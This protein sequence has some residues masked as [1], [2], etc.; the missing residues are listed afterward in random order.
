MSSWH[1]LTKRLRAQAVPNPAQESLALMEYV[2]G[3]PAATILADE[4]PLRKRQRRRLRRLADRRQKQPLAYLLGQQ[5]FYGL[6]FII[7][8]PVLI[9]RPESEDMVE[10]AL[11]LPQ[12]FNQVYDLGSGSGCLGI[13]YAHAGGC[14][15]ITFIDRDQRAL[16]LTALNSQIHGL[17]QARYQ[18]RS[19][20]TMTRADFRAGSLILANLP[21]LD[22]NQ[23]QTFEDHCPTLKREAAGALYA[24]E[25]GLY[26]Y[27]LLFQ[28]CPTQTTLLCESLPTQQ[29]R[30][31]QLA[32]TTGWQLRHQHNFISMFTN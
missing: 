30:L 17:H 26:Y 11:S 6:N 31:A 24:P 9:P 21:Y 20:E 7:K 15:P 12:T 10:L 19:L 32:Q 23:R 14:Q 29:D 5:Q 22:I 2:T 28:R 4:I 8:P 13:A 25:S 16:K 1:Q 18:R 3:Q 27:R